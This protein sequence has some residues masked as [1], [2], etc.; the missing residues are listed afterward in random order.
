MPAILSSLCRYRGRSWRSGDHP[1]SLGYLCP[2]GNSRYV[3]TSGSGSGSPI[4]VYSTFQRCIPEEGSRGMTGSWIPCTILYA[5]S[6]P[7]IFPCAARSARPAMRIAFA[8]WH[9]PDDIS[10]YAA[11][12]SAYCPNRRC[13]SPESKSGISSFPDAETE[14]LNPS[15]YLTRPCILSCPELFSGTK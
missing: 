9:T 7:V 13:S 15:R 6:S 1:A 12:P 11:R 14:P 4:S 3:K 10:I 2:P 8:G 5:I